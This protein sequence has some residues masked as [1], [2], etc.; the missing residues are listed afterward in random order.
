MLFRSVA[1]A[2][3]ETVT[4]I[5]RAHG[6]NAKVVEVPPGPPVLSPIV[7]EVYGPDYTG[8]LAVA[9]QV[10]EVFDTT[11]DIVGADDTLDETAPKLVLRV[12]QAKAALMGV[13]QAQIVEVMRLGLAGESVTPLHGGDNKYEIP[14][15][16]QLP[17]SQQST[18]AHLLQIGRAHV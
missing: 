2:V 14:V 17:P 4:A 15:R 12:N 16:I 11:A 13:A 3:R 10:R 8:Q 18:V 7:A 1:G 5:A 6:G 9:Q